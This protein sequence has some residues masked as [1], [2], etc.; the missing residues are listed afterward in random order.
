[1]ATLIEPTTEKPRRPRGNLTLRIRDETR[2]KMQR[3][4]DRLGYSLSEAV[5][6]MIENRLNPPE[7]SVLSSEDKLAM[8][9]LF[10]AYRHGPGRLVERV[11]QIMLDEGDENRRRDEWHLMQAALIKHRL[12]HPIK[13][14]TP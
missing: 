7:D 13:D 9:D 8:L 1:M 4:A 11:L 10:I 6:I 3:E 12:E 2:E 14:F 5:E